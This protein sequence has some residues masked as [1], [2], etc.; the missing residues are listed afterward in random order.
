MMFVSRPLI[1]RLNGAESLKEAKRKERYA[2][3]G[4]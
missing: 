1:E 2:S 3:N 4:E